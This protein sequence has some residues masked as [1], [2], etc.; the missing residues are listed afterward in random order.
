MPEMSSPEYHPDAKVL[1][2]VIEAEVP[3]LFRVLSPLGRRAFF[4]RDIPF[5][6]G[7][8]RDT[9]YN[10]TIGIFT[11]GHGNAVP[12]PSMGKV[13]QLP[14]DEHN[15]A[16]LYSPVGGIPEVREAW[17]TWQRREQP[18]ELVTSLPVVT[19]G[20][21]HGLA[22][23]ADLFGGE[24]RHVAVP[25]P[26]WGN[27]RQTFGI[28]TGAKVVGAPSYADGRF[29]P[30]VFADALASAPEGEPALV[31]VNFPSNPGGYCPTREERAEIRRSLIAVAE[32]RPLVVICDDAYT[33]V[34]YDPEIPKASM[35]W[36]LLGTHPRLFP[37]K[38]DGATK[39]YSFFGGR[40]GFLTFGFA[41]DSAVGEA[42]TSK[43]M[44]LVRAG[45]GS[46]GATSQ[47]ILLQALKSGKAAEEIAGVQAIADARYSAL[48]PCLQAL[49]PELLRPLPFNA[50]YF[51][52]MELPE[53]LGL[54][55][56]E[57]RLHL[58]A[59][60]DTGVVAIKPN[61][62]RLAIC[63]VAAEQIPEMVRRVEKGVRELAAKRLASPA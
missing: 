60:H 12:L 2:S 26:F 9:T 45:I 34:V 11:D 19:A 5:Q 62:L 35:F 56:D 39:E 59:E 48:A 37:V 33:G 41:P 32:K 21:A 14:K 54:S 17:R 36:E 3:D 44:G 22:L 61:Y 49:D 6:A 16:F 13:V 58:I 42:L 43:T 8:A 10:G 28:R 23:A 31:I 1:N 53:S 51:V 63:S 7:Q 52:L 29:R 38:V 4:P 50:G 18:E 55:P 47:I 46:P 15:R 57:I 25:E 40:V 27:Y 30:E 24:G 20:L